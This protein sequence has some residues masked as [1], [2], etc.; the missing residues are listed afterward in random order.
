[1][2]RSHVENCGSGSTVAGCEYN[3]KTPDALQAATA[4]TC[5]ATGFIS[6]DPAFQ[7]V[8]G[9]EVIVLDELLEI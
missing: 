2:D 3:L 8:A 1:M 5:G 9:L 4:L 6:N 7:R